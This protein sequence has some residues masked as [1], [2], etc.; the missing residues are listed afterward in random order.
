MKC[1]TFNNFS[2]EHRKFVSIQKIK[3]DFINNL[4]SSVTIIN[5]MRATFFLLPG[6][7]MYK[8]NK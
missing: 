8:M 1:I 6:R 3:I 5:K 4:Y 7:K 2:Q